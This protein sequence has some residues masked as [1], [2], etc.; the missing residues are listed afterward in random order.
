MKRSNNIITFLFAFGAGVM[1]TGAVEGNVEAA[2][3]GALGAVL[4]LAALYVNN[5]KEA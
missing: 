3:W 1:F 5:R 4:A 2:A